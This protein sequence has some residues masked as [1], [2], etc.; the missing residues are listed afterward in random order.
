MVGGAEFFPAK[1]LGTS[2]LCHDLQKLLM[3]VTELGKSIQ[4]TGY[5]QTPITGKDSRWDSGVQNG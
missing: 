3:A 1:D 5:A 2:N 4:E